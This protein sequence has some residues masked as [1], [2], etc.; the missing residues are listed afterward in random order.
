[1]DEGRREAFGGSVLTT[2]DTEV[3]REKPGASRAFALLT[4]LH[5]LLKI[6]TGA[7]NRT[8]GGEDRKRCEDRR[9]AGEPCEVAGVA[10]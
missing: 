4:F 7:P 5:G 3:H 6:E 8:N 2:E 1:M 10:L 9:F